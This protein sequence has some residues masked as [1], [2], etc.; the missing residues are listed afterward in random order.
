MA[1]GLSLHIG[2]NRVDAQRYAGWDGVL[3]ACEADARDMAALAKAQGFAGS[4]LTTEHA[5]RD[6]VQAAITD[7]ARALAAGDIFL[8][9]Y[10]GHGGQ[11]PDLDDDEPDGM[12]ETWCLYDGQLLDDELNALWNCFAAGVRVLVVSDSC[13]S[14]TVVRV[15][16]SVRGSDAIAASGLLA[17][18]GIEKPV[19]RFMPKE[20]ALRT[21]R[22]NRALYE[23][24]AAKA[25]GV[26]L[27]PKATVRLLSG[28]QDNQLSMDGTFNGLFTGT[29]LRVWKHGAFLGDYAAFHRSIVRLMPA[30]QTP[31]HFLVG[32]PNPAF[33]VE[34]PFTV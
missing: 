34:K 19:Y 15:V 3:T 18:H 16:S 4:L 12:D 9:T 5:R 8:L 14:G 33:D 1:R 28:C 10:S 23:G 7:A 27:E 2:L 24:W 26:R 29:L 17:E 31:N 22:E 25:R 11:I 30:T 20:V 21:F 32:P 6:A 13:H